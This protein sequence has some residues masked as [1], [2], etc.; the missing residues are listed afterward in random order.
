MT[1]PKIETATE[2]GRVTLGMG[3]GAY[4]ATGARPE[5]GTFARFAY[6]GGAVLEAACGLGVLVEAGLIQRLTGE[7]HY[8]AASRVFGRPYA[9]GFAYGFDGDPIPAER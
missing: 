1:G 6:P 5:R 7:V 4:E 2:Q 9:E 8:D 3:V